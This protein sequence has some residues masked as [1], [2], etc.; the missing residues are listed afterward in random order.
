MDRLIRLLASAARW[1]SYI[2][3]SVDPAWIESV[4][5]SRAMY[6]YLSIWRDIA[7][8]IASLVCFYHVLVRFFS[9]NRRL[10]CFLLSVQHF[11]TWFI[12]VG[13]ELVSTRL[14]NWSSSSQSWIFAV[15]SSL[16][17]TTLDLPLS[18]LSVL[19][20]YCSVYNSKSCWKQF[21]G[22]W[23]LILRS[24]RCGGLL[25]FLLRWSQLNW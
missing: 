23:V 8:Q 14:Y 22:L 7:R 6:L 12:T 11:L 13:N 1:H 4:H 18:R 20:A 2:C 19:R 21:V 10:F 24:L 15:Y 5:E 17:M 3:V 25:V 16:F 9:W